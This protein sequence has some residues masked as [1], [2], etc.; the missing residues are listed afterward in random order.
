MCKMSDAEVVK[1]VVTD[2]RAFL[3]YIK[4]L[5]DTVSE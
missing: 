5:F 3:Q 4:I 1:D 2:L